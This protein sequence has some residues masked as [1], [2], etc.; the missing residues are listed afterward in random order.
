M[1]QPFTIG[2]VGLGLMGASL[3][4]ALR[5]FRGATLLGADS[6]ALVCRRAQAAGA[7]HHATTDTAQVMAQADLLLFCVYAHHIP[8]LLEVHGARLRP[9]C[10]CGDICGVKT[11]L[12]R[13]ITPLLPPEIDYVGVHPMAGKERDGYENADAALYRNSGFLITPLPRSSPEGIATMRALAGYIGATRLSV[14]GPEEHDQLIAY[15][16][17]LMHVAAAGLCLHPQPGINPAFTA[18]AFRDCTRIADINAAAWTELLLDNRA[19]TVARLEQYMEDLSAL[20][21]ALLENDAPRLHALLCQAGENKRDM[22]Q[23]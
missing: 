11:R 12:Y 1:A 3:A 4:L 17:D 6:D 18:G 15:T 13:R 20:R 23:Q 8:P 7:V 16:S 22:L 2:V 21:S 19:N 10:L 9:G 14:V 5:G